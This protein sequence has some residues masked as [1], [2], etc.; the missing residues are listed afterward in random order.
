MR[1]VNENENAYTNDNCN[2]FLVTTSQ[3][4]SV[5]ACGEM[6]LVSSLEQH[7]NIIDNN[8]NY[9]AR[10]TN[11]MDSSITRVCVFC[12]VCRV[13]AKKRQPQIPDSRNPCSHLDAVAVAV[14][15]TAA[16]VAIPW[17]IIYFSLWQG[18]RYLAVNTLACGRTRTDKT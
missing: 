1:A 3:H 9:L 4:S 12:S 5:L 11:K 15:A 6:S 7:K 16:A 10:D 14:A 8:Y 17:L 13:A 2:N 18:S